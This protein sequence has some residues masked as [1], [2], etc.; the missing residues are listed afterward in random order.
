M[1]LGITYFS[2]L[3]LLRRP[4]EVD[5]GFSYRTDFRGLEILPSYSHSW[6]VQQYLGAC[7]VILT[8][9]GWVGFVSGSSG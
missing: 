7:G 4:E 8:R 1:L 9:G 5:L 6:D 3:S 2:C